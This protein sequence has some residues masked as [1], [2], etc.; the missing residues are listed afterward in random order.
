[1]L[2]KSLFDPKFIIFSNVTRKISS[3][4][5]AVTRMHRSIYARYLILTENCI[6]TLQL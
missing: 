4:S 1:M 2:L 6:I 3:S 5:A